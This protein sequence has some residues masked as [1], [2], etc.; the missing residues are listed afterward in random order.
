MVMITPKIMYPIRRVFSI[1]LNGYL[2][3]YFASLTLNVR[4]AAATIT[5]TENV[6]GGMGPALEGMKKPTTTE[7]T[8]I[9]EKSAKYREITLIWSRLSRMAQS[10]QSREDTV[11]WDKIISIDYTGIERVTKK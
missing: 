6:S 11:K 4:L 5:P 8:R 3:S 1:L 10:Y 9:L 7:A 2:C